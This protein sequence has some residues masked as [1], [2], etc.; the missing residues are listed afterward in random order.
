M[1]SKKVNLS[2]FIQDVHVEPRGQRHRPSSSKAARP[3]ACGLQS[4]PS[5]PGK[6]A[7]SRAPSLSCSPHRH[8]CLCPSPSRPQASSASSLLPTSWPHSTRAWTPQASIL[9]VS[10]FPGQSQCPTFTAALHTLKPAV[11][12]GPTHCQVDSLGFHTGKPCRK[13]FC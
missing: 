5:A 3:C 11:Q 9:Q 13:G 7:P 12:E 10:P 8:G 1:A 6:L 2:F 4:R